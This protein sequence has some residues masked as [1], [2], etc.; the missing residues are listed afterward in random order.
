VAESF[1]PMPAG[2]NIGLDD[3]SEADDDD[4]LFD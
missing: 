3:F 4:S 1:T 2:G